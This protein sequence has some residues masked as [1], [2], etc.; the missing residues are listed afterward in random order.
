MF[1]PSRIAIGAG[2]VAMSMNLCS[3]RQVA[4][5][6]STKNSAFVFIKP[7]ANTGKAQHLV[8]RSFAT[9]GIKVLEEGEL[10]GE[11]IDEGKLIDQHYY[12]IASKATLLQPNQLPVP[13]QKF[14]D[15]FG[16][17]WEKA[18][19]DGE[20][21]NALDA[22]KFWGITAD[23]L[24]KAWGPAKKVK[25]GG[26]FYCGLVNIPGK[27]PL[28]VFNGFFMSMRAKFVTPGTSIHY[29]VVEFDPAEL[30]WSDFR[31][32]VLGPTNPKEAPADS[33]RGK[34][35]SDWK[36]LGLDYE[37]NVGDN[38]VHA[39]ASPFEGL[40]ER[41]NWLKKDIKDD[42]FGARLIQ[43]GVPVDTIKAWSVDPQVKGKSLFDALEDMDA[44]DCIA[45][46]VELSKR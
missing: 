21:Y 39:S 17:S 24:D 38:G 30:S 9:K 46:A 31:G 4:S 23:E 14:Q 27:K 22:C 1:T 10:T 35:L 16:V 34:I 40:A 42:S 15:T 6:D 18:L 19:K 7:H 8:K 43:S 5:C 33:L 11:Q 45:K 44:D 29:Y 41:T 28:Y 12:A 25:F 2:L 36:S 20:V 37:P 26:G 32:K 3:S 13:A